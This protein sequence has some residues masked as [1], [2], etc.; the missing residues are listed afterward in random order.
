MHTLSNREVISTPSFKPPLD[1]EEDTI[2]PVLSQLPVLLVEK[3][4]LI[5]NLRI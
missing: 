4:G 3:K 1:W 2:H 5:G